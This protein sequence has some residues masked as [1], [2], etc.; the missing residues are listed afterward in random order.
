MTVL[1]TGGAG[2]T[3]DK[4]VLDWLAHSKE[5]VLNLDKL[6]YVG[7]L[8][9]VKNWQYPKPTEMSTIGPST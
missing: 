3:D 9:P 4:F 8:P 5:T 7:N 6:T 2:F 1:I